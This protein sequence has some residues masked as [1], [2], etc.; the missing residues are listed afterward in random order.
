M[1]STSHYTPD[2]S[3]FGKLILVRHAESE[4]NKLGKWTGLS[5]VHLSKKGSSDAI[6]LGLCLQ[7]IEID[8]VYCSEQVRTVETME[9]L[10]KAAKNETAKITRNKNLNERDYGE[11]TGLDKWEVRDRVGDMTFK[12]IRRGWDYP[13]IGGETLKMVFARVVP[14]YKDFIIPELMLGKNVVIIS[15]GNTLRALVKYIES[16]D[17][18]AIDGLEIPFDEILIFQIKSDGRVVSKDVRSITITPTFA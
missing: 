2:Q 9:I 5:D 8:V 18:T 15:H 3:S 14:F 13:I 7:D 17:D 16:I 4:W 6:L 11:Y 12:K 10:L 1:T